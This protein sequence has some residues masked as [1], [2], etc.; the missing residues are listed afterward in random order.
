MKKLPAILWLVAITV[1]SGYPGNK[2][3]EAPFV[4]FDKLVHLA[5]YFILS[6]SICFAW[7]S[8]S[9]SVISTNFLIA[10]FGIFYGGFMEISQ[11]FIFINRSGSWIDFFANS[12]GSILGVVF[13]PFILKL[14]PFK[15]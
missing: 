13:Y 6:I 8:K 1:L 7:C 3:P 9:K 15:R 14:L 11:H 2:I 12:L 5:I 10:S 4:N